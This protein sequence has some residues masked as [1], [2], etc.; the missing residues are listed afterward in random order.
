MYT[1]MTSAAACMS[2]YANLAHKQA[3][4]IA[5]S[6]GSLIN[7][8]N[9]NIDFLTTISS[10]KRARK[11]TVSAAVGSGE[12]DFEDTR[13]SMLFTSHLIPVKLIYL[14]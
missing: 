13:L 14:C 11:G 1:T 9:Q 8:D 2:I 6:M 10:I 12:D 3:L 7:S 5:Y 4:K